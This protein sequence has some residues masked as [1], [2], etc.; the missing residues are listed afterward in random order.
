MQPDTSAAESP[1]APAP[2]TSPATS[3]GTG[4]AAARLL[5]TALTH[6]RGAALRLAGWTLLQAV[7][8]LVSGKVLALAVDHGFL[9]HRPWQAAGWLAVF[10]AVTFAGAW[11]SRQAYPW[12]AEIVE[13]LRDRLLRDVVTG[14]LHRAAAARGRPDGSAAVA[15]A[16]LTRQVE[17]VRDAAAGQ[18]L[19]VS[20]FALTAVAVVAGTAALAPAAVPPVALP[21]LASLAVF[22][23]LAPVTVRRQRAAFAAE[24]ELARLSV[25]TLQAMRDLTA[26][27]AQQRAGREVLASVAANAAAGRSLA[28]VAAARRLVVSLGAHLPLLLLV[29][30]A[31]SLVRHGLTAG[32]VVGVLAYV[33]GTLEPALRLLVQ[34]VGASWL[35]MAVAADRLAV[36]AR[37]PGPVAG[38]VPQDV[39]QDPAEPDAVVRPVPGLRPA[40]GSV[41][42][43]RVSF[44]YGAAA[45]PVLDGFD[46]AVADGEHLAVVGP[47][48]IGKST[49]AD[50]LAGI[51][52]PD[53]GHVRLGGVP[54]GRLT[55]PELA[56]ARVLLP[57]DP[58][59]FAGPLGD[60][61][62]WLAPGTPDAAVAAAAAEL[63][64]EALLRRP[65]GL[66][67]PLD[68][69][70][71][72]PGERQLVAL[73]RAYLSPA[74]LVV[75]DEATRHLDAEAELRVDLAF[76][77]RPGAVIGITHRAGPARR[78]DRILLL[79]GV[80]PR[81]G[82]H[83]HLLATS[84]AYRELVGGAC[85]VT[86]QAAAGQA[87]AG[88]AAA[89]QAG[90][91]SSRD[92]S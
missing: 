79:D 60:N 67:G 57:Q 88:Q 34:G 10:A 30:A 44:S 12:L 76:R 58:Y 16:Q 38:P 23:A 63:G 33:T 48:G 32:E 20:Q 22:A 7:P 43:S 56:R 19:V 27:G 66:S 81:L 49:L 39:P 91:V 17:A 40:D 87:V 35:R 26:Y 62:R 37:L 85:P 86:G 70:E 54:L 45:E 11:A 15:V 1:V 51:V 2:A 18:L 9:G 29:V 74:R 52:P 53:R 90:R 78:A 82:T 61:L 50:V 65:G 24:E 73:V 92:G 36:A 71:L 69:T 6:S 3:T 25:G 47:S 68:P 89:G 14:T 8:A 28:R 4:R 5:G 77:R 80:L 46:L 55:G 41:T 64:A 72:S 42:A 31:P 13:P 84:P 59:V 21:L 75:L 83:E